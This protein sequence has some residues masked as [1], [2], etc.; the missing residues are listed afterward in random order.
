MSSYTE[1]S[2]Y[3]CDEPDVSII[4]PVYNSEKYIFRT[5]KSALKQTLKNV[6]VIV[7][8]DGSTDATYEV[9][10][11][12]KNDNRL[13][14]YRQKNKGV[15]SARNLGIDKCTGR[16]IMFLDSDDWLEKKAVEMLFEN[17]EK[18]KLTLVCCGRYDCYSFGN[19][20]KK[21]RY[22]PPSEEGTESAYDV[23]LEVCS[24]RYG[25]QS[26]CHKLY[27]RRIVEDFHIRFNDNIYNCE[28]GLFVFEYLSYM[29]SIFY[30]SVPLW[31]VYHHRG[32]ATRSPYN[33]K[34]F[35]AIYAPD[36]MLKLCKDKEMKKRVLAYKGIVAK[37]IIKRAIMS[38]DNCIEDILFLRKTMQESK[39]YYFKYSNLRGIIAYMFFNYMPISVL[40]KIMPLYYKYY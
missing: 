39:R 40:K 25:I 12:F 16:Y 1:K 18:K 11:V 3:I 8:D 28:D 36:E 37:E 15:S 23:M 33:H 10:K 34:V 6:E 38:Q 26:S 20:I 29:R 31:N 2:D 13:K 35:T 17:A 19:K 32:S 30:L 21:K 24:G 5:V 22:I 27:E 4:I 14:L 7:V 9:L